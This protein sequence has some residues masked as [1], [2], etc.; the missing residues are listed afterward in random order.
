MCGVVLILGATIAHA[1]PCP[2]LFAR[3]NADHARAVS[4]MPAPIH[5]SRDKGLVAIESRL[6][7]ALSRC[8]KNADLFALMG[9]VQIS[10]SQ[11]PLAIAYGRKAVGLDDD[12]WRALH[13]LGS[14]LALGGDAARGLPHLERAVHLAPD[15]LPLRLNLASALLSAGDHVRVIDVCTELVSSGNPEVVRA[16]YNLRGRAYVETGE[17]NEAARDFAN[18]RRLGFDPRRELI[19]MDALRRRLEE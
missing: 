2:Q 1:E 18:A 6:F 8:P 15:N 16:A 14:A 13:L 5:D 4:A 7:D 19:D 17:L 9:E 10:L 12:S 11:V 3:L